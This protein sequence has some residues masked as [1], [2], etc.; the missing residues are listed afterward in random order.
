MDEFRISDMT[1]EAVFESHEACAA[2][3][4]CPDA[5]AGDSA[6]SDSAAPR[7]DRARGGAPVPQ[8]HLR[9]TGIRE[10]WARWGT[11]GEG[12]RVA[13]IDSGVRQSHRDLAQA[14]RGA[15][16]YTHDACPEL[17]EADHGTHVCGIIAAADNGDNV[18]GVA[19]GCEVHS[20]KVFGRKKACRNENILRALRD[21]KR[22]KYGQIDIINMSLGSPSPD[23]AIRLELL[24]LSAM[25]VICVCAAGNSGDHAQ[26]SAPRFG[27]T[28]F[29]AAYNS[30]LC[31]GATDSRNRRTAFS[32]T[33]PRVHVMA[34]GDS[35]LS[36]WNTGDNAVAACS[37]TSMA[38]PFVAGVVALLLSYCAKNGLARPGLDETLYCLA[39]S[40]NNMEAAGFDDFTGF[41]LVDPAGTIQ[42]YVDLHARKIIR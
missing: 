18:T 16:N 38:A 22:G 39:S 7:S 29:P 21:I 3:C 10:C 11:A 2:A 15:Y 42:K 1:V 33:G 30:T 14:V 12:V 8:W 35:I 23:N 17:E 25:G 32:S 31:V 4:P 34:P 37:G 40:A 28:D 41:G 24:E 26:A 27:T 5:A 36:T 9:N 20:F 19:P 6:D 13:V